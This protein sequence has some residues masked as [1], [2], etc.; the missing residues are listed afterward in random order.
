MYEPTIPFG[1]PELMRISAFRRYLDELDADA[2]QG[3]AL[4]RLTTISGS[5]AQDLRSFE[6]GDAGDE[7]LA[8]LAGCIRH[9]QRAVI[10]LRCDDIVVPITVFPMERL[11]YCPIELST[12][13]SMR[14]SQMSVMRVEP[15]VLRP[16]GDPE[17]A[18]VGEAH[19]HFPL[20]VLAWELALRGRRDEL[21][22]EIRGPAAYRVAPGLDVAALQ[23]SGTLL[24]AVQRL[25]RE[26]TNLR[27]LSELPGMNR[28]RAVRLLNGLYLQSGLI[29]SR[30]HPQASSDSWFGGLGR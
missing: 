27:D 29:V 4:S 15:A 28:E 17:T 1:E 10:H 9:A 5:L 7:T 11:A 18:L 12:L 13:L 25:Q 6:G 21:L 3:G 30:T 8:T 26:G 19:L 22:P 2:A 14:L 23:L 20:G 16:P 24:A